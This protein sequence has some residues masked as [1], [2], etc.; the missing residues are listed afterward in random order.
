MTIGYERPLLRPAKRVVC[1]GCLIDADYLDG[2]TR[3]EVQVQAADL[4]IAAGCYI[5]PDIERLIAHA[6]EHAGTKKR[7]G[8]L[9]S[10]KGLDATEHE[11]G[12]YRT[13]GGKPY[14]VTLYV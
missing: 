8:K 13:F 1:L 3:A 5:A 2:M 4:V 6:A 14:A 10:A 12:F 11:D 9:P 7:P